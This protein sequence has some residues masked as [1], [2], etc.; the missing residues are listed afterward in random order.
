[1]KKYILETGMHCLMVVV[2][3][4]FFLE[5]KKKRMKIYIWWKHGYIIKVRRSVG[6]PSLSS[7]G[8]AA[9]FRVLIA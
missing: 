7:E 2:A 4:I 1:M 9:Q 8:G 3:V 6:N 5:R